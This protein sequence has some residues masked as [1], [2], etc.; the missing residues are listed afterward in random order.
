MK[1][2]NKILPMA[3]F[4][5]M[6]INAH[7]DTS[8]RHRFLAEDGI[9]ISIRGITQSP[10][11]LPG[12]GSTCDPAV[13]RNNLSKVNSSG[14]FKDLKLT[15]TTTIGAPVP[16]NIDIEAVERAKDLHCEK[17]ELLAHLVEHLE[18]RVK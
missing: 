4:S 8:E 10:V 9:Q 15:F 7:A 11:P 17:A 18:E 14:F 5:L 13:I 3:M 16:Y 2:K 1:T 6:S 12:D